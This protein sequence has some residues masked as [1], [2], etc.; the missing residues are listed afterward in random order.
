MK[1]LG[2]TSDPNQA[3]TVTL[4]DSAGD[5]SQYVIDAQF[6]ERDC[7][8]AGGW[9]W[10]LSDANGNVLLANVPLALRVDMLSP[11]GL[12][13]GGMVALDMDN[14]G[15]EPGPDDLGTGGRVQVVW[16]DSDDLATLA[17]AGVAL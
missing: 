10:G 13:V 9:V 3:F 6:N 8:E 1:V 17:A 12:D 7:D 2:F 11:W 16:L 15:V 5:A 14:T 4:R